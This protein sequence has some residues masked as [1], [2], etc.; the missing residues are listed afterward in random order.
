VGEV[1]EVIGE[2]KPKYRA[3]VGSKAVVRKIY[4]KKIGH[5]KYKDYIFF[6]EVEGKDA[7]ETAKFSAMIREQ[8]Q[9]CFTDFLYANDRSL[10]P[11]RPLHIRFFLQQRFKQATQNAV[12][13]TT[14]AEGGSKRARDDDSQDDSKKARL[15]DK[16][17]AA[18]KERG[19]KT[20]RKLDMAPDS[21]DFIPDHPV[22][23]GDN[24]EILFVN[25]P[26]VGGHQEN[27]QDQFIGFQGV[28]RKL[29]KTT[30]YVEAYIELQRNKA[31]EPIQKHEIKDIKDW[32]NY[33][34]RL[35]VKEDDVSWFRVPSTYVVLADPK[36]P[37]SFVPETWAALSV[38]DRKMHRKHQQEKTPQHATQNVHV[39]IGDNV[40][41][42]KT[43]PGYSSDFIGFQGTV[44][45]IMGLGCSTDKHNWYTTCFVELQRNQAGESVTQDQLKI[46]ENFN[47]DLYAKHQWSKMKCKIEYLDIPDQKTPAQAIGVPVKKEKHDEIPALN[48][49][50]IKYDLMAKAPWHGGEVKPYLYG[51][52]VVFVLEGKRGEPIT[53]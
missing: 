14:A 9:R 29:E 12:T 34:Y 3:F 31:G 4:G 42:L 52:K 11:C 25:P 13:V 51:R 20:R 8:N 23:I 41:I 43:L 49:R 5:D 15:Q 26:A 50:H 19:G 48:I 47:R 1:V 39:R 36:L 24:V 10:L 35:H 6:L 32:N 22:T 28:I 21:K 38:K 17:D 46:I 2:F 16:D 40:E 33:L 45:S 30:F 7:D 37:D 27:R 53:R 44:T 18:Q